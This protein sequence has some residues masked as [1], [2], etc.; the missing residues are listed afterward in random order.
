MDTSSEEDEEQKAFRALLEKD[1]A[2]KPRKGGQANA[3]LLRKFTVK[4]AKEEIEER[5]KAKPSVSMTSGALRNKQ[6]MD[7]V[8]EEQLGD[9]RRKE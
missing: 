6:K 5:A 1:L 4:G 8:F 9:Q 3:T 7:R 2:T